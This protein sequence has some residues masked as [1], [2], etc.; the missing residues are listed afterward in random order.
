MEQTYR[1]IDNCFGERAEELTDISEHSQALLRTVSGWTV[2]KFT[3]I[4]T[5]TLID[6]SQ[7][8]EVIAFRNECDKCFIDTGNVMGVIRLK[9][10]DSKH[11]LLLEIK[12]RFDAGGKQLFLTY[13]LTKVFGGTF[14]DISIPTDTQSLWDML[15][16][17]HFKRQFSRA[18]IV[19]LYKQYE[20]FNHN[21]LRF[22]GKFDLNR[23][24]K[25]NLPCLGH[26]AYSTR[27]ISF[28]NPINHLICHAFLRIYRKWP[29]I[30]SG[31][32]EITGF[33]Q[34]LEQNTPSWEPHHL[35]QLLRSRDLYSPIKNS[36]FASYYEPLRRL[37]LAVLSDE[38]A[39]LYASS[40]TEDVEGVLFDG[41]WLWEEYINTLLR[42]EGFQHPE[43][44]TK[45]GA[46]QI[47]QDNKSYPRYPDFY[48]KTS[49][50]EAKYKG[51][52]PSKIDRD[53][54]HQMVTYMYL[55]KASIG[56]FLYPQSDSNK[57]ANTVGYLHGFGG[58][59][60]TLPFD[61]PGKID[62]TSEFL[63]HISLSENKFLEYIRKN[64]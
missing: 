39:D 31:D 6:D 26:L 20:V 32:S 7:D 28:D 63:K 8:S 5:N 2:S 42:D 48:R 23:H 55:R 54:M 47:F 34:K 62:S 43:N 51:I 4:G 30:F 21:D 53:D 14:V 17:F 25:N 45:R 11:S 19:G 58:S 13:L 60:I 57:E 27:D 35:A 44:K 46:I 50:L 37:S 40:Q 15:L 49:V 1:L 12:S 56:A 10:E 24:L 33:L 59:I 3:A 36:F 9:N 16:A 38:G 18:A 52:I 64:C 29:G 41:A 22:R 61:V